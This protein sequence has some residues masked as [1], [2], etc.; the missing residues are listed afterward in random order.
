MCVERRHLGGAVFS[1]GQQRTLV[2]ETPKVFWDNVRW[3]VWGDWGGKVYYGLG[4][5][6]RLVA[7]L[8]RGKTKCWVVPVME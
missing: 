8:V 3:V 2:P 5:T 6:L 7:T 4:A 1:R